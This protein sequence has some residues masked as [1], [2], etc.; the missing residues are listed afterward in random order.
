MS[1]DFRRLKTVSLL[2]RKHLVTVPAFG[3]PQPGSG[4]GD[5]IET[6]P[7]ILAARSLKRLVA[8]LRDARAKG[9]SIIWSIGAH[10]LKCGLAPYLTALMERRYLTHL[11]MNGAGLVHDFEIAFCGETSEDV[12]ESIAD[13][14]FGTAEETGRFLGQVLSD[15]YGRSL[16]LGLGAL[17][18]RR[19]AVDEL[20]HG[21]HS[22]L[23]RA[24]EL[25][26]PATIHAALGADVV[27]IHPAVD[28]ERLGGLLKRDFEVFAAGL[29]GLSDGGVYL[30]VGS[31][32]LLPEVF[33][34]AL[35]LVRNVGKRVDGFTAVN[36]DM[37]QHYRPRVNVLERP[38]GEPIQIIGHHEILIPLLAGALMD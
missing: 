27:H 11:A 7:D 16:G 15:D 18:G 14:S 22:L 37:Q 35:S 9:R 34:K 31:A 8:A 33:L 24:W 12:A 36:L 29:P 20:P 13:G 3:R 17:L 28:W 4:I 32:V 21:Q 38:G 1:F 10:V 23:A 5:W 6:L 2:R 30:N 19:I 26:V 25:K